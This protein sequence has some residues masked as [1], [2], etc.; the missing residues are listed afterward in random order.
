MYHWMAGLERAPGRRERGTARSRCGRYSM[1]TEL[2]NESSMASTSEEG[3]TGCKIQLN[4]NSW[5]QECQ[6]TQKRN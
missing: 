6:E 2:N 5:S 4:L 1:C 3:V